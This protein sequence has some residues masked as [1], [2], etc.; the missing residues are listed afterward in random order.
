MFFFLLFSGFVG[1]GKFQVTGDDCRVQ[2][3]FCKDS[4]NERNASSLAYCRVQPIFCK[5]SANHGK[6]KTKSIS[7]DLRKKNNRKN[8]LQ[9]QRRQESKERLKSPYNYANLT[10][11]FSQTRAA[12]PPFSV[13]FSPE[14]PSPPCRKTLPGL[15]RGHRRRATAAPLRSRKSPAASP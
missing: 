8:I 15:Q 11:F 2:P 13:R 12:V 7:F 4:A 3:V 1:A 6:S 9:Q 5:D 14:K 10:F